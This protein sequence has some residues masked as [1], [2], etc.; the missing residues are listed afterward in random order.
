VKYPPMHV[1]LLIIWFITIPVIVTYLIR[2]AGNYFGYNE[3][4]KTTQIDDYDTIYLNLKPSDI[5]ISDYMFGTYFDNNTYF[6]N[7][8][9]RVYVKPKMYIRKNTDK[10]KLQFVRTSRGKNKRTAFRLA[11]DINYKVEVE[12]SQITIPP[13]FTIEPLNEWK[14]QQVKIILFIPENTVIIVDESLCYSDII[15]NPRQSGHDGN[16]CKWIMT[17]EGIRAL[18]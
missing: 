13:Y 10:P 14:S 6:D 1:V 4:I 5:E 12:N 8:D 16:A 15:V 17:K 11:N 2:E 9:N 7:D 3:S 18:D